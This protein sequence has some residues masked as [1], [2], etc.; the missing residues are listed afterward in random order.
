MFKGTLRFFKQQHWFSL[1][2]YNFFVKYNPRFLT[3]CKA[4]YELNDKAFFYFY[5]NHSYIL[6]FS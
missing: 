6:T 4:M 1:Y 2:D 3:H 5:R